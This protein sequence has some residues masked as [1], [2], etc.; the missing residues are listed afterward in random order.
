ML[1]ILWINWHQIVLKPTAYTRRKK[2]YFLYFLPSILK[3]LKSILKLK[4]IFLRK[5]I[6]LL[7]KNIKFKWIE[8]LPAWQYK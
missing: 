1:T 7:D 4:C 3:I 8:Y 5:L 2:G 6:F